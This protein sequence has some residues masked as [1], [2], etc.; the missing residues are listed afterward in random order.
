MANFTQSFISW[1]KLTFKGQEGQER[2]CNFLF[3]N[4]WELRLMQNQFLSKKN[5]FWFI[6]NL[7]LVEFEGVYCTVAYPCWPLKAKKFSSKHFFLRK[8]SMVKIW[9]ISIHWF[10]RYRGGSKSQTRQGVVWVK[11]YN[12]LEHPNSMHRSFKCF[13]QSGRG[14]EANPDSLCICVFLFL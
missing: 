14:T 2:P 6:Q 1:K 9:L 3:Q 12:K 5:H 13:P 4:F 11:F 10:L 7:N 8:W